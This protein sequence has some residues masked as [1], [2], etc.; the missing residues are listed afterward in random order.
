M[1]K[2]EDL[3]N[4]IKT[5]VKNWWV[6]TILGIVFILLG[7]WVFR[8]PLEGYLGLSLYF[9]I[10]MFIGGIVQIY[11]SIS[12][13][14][15]L[16][17]WGWQLMGGIL[18][19]LFGYMLTNNPQITMV[20]LPFFVGFW[21]LFRSISL[22]SFSLELRSLLLPNWWLYLLFAVL[23]GIFAFFILTKP[24]IGGITIITWTGISLIIAGIAQIAI[25][26]DL[27]KLHTLGKKVL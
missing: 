18:Q 7:I 23:I 3:G 1:S 15:V 26:M 5:A 24:V 21:L 4:Q 20:I 22:A 14:D 13:K 2:L 6:L 11:F 10:A 16:P 25:S 9:S 12:N 8:N 27:K 19:V 17:G